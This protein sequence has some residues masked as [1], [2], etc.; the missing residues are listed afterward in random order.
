MFVLESGNG[1]REVSTPDVSESVMTVTFSPDLPVW[2]GLETNTVSLSLT[3]IECVM[4][5]R[6]G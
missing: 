2:T 1:T 4:V 3:V 5:P 6:I